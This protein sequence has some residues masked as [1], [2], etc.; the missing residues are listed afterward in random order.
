[1]IRP[2]KQQSTNF[3]G[4][5][6]GMYKTPEVY[7]SVAKAVSKTQPAPNITT[8]AQVEAK[9]SGNIFQRAKH[10]VMNVAKGFNNVKNTTSG[11]IKGIKEG[12]V[13]G[14]IVGT[15]GK[16]LL[17]AKKTIEAEAAQSDKGFRL[18]KFAF[19]TVSGTIS[20]IGSTALKAVKRLP[21]L[22]TKAPKNNLKA[23][24]DLP[25][26]FI[27]YMGSKKLTAVAAAVAVGAVALRTLQ[28]KIN[29]NRA[30]ANIDHSL[31]EGH[32]K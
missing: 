16:N 21:D 14:T 4:A 13:A 9:P 19:K 17:N 23:V 11:F 2:I 29:A 5:H 1:M 27:K 32:I 31:N 18:G 26:K 15:V 6:Q 10:S 22:Y 3:K 24:K 28:G 30:N 7:Q 8:N 12:V 25:N 20:D